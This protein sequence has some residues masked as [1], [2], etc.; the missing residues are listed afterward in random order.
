[1]LRQIN[2]HIDFCSFYRTDSS[3]S[4]EGDICNPDF[5]KELFADLTFR[6]EE[7]TRYQGLDHTALFASS[8]TLTNKYA[9]IG[10]NGYGKHA[11]P[12]DDVSFQTN[13]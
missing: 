5:F 4:V 1:M 13:S 2:L 3:H 10:S 11:L 8:V 12:T 9:V 6:P 7:Y